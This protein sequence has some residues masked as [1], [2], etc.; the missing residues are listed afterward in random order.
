MPLKKVTQD[1]GETIA[2]NASILGIT[3]FADFELILKILLLLLSCGYTISRW[4]AHCKK[5]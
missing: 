3:T 5:K 4:Y 1:I 2:V